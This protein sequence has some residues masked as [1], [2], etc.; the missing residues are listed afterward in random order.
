M[1]HH[2]GSLCSVPQVAIATAP[3]QTDSSPCFDADQSE[4]ALY[5]DDRTP[6]TAWL[7]RKNCLF[8]TEANVRLHDSHARHAEQTNAI[9]CSLGSAE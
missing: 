3:P 2:R 7:F 9:A 5:F 6:G 1:L 8:L 4:S